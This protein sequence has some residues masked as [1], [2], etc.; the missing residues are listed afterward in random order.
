MLFEQARKGAGK[1]L[2]LEVRSKNGPAIAFYKKLGYGIEERVSM[3]KRLDTTPD[4][5]ER[6]R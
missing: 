5:R 4:T 2:W 3:G 6:P 1:R